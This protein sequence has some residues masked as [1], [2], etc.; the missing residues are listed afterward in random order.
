MPTYNGE[1]FLAAALESVS[2]QYDDRIELVI[3]DD[4]SSDH[5][6]DIVRGFAECSSHSV[7]H[8]REVR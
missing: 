1:K 4:G 2:D 8:S 7:D 6:L 3:V 5:T